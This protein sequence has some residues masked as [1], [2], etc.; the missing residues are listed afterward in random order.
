MPLQDSNNNKDQNRMTNSKKGQN[1]H[2]TNL[3]ES[4]RLAQSEDITPS[5][6]SRM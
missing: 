1:K 2:E 5:A 4:N 3:R 6:Q